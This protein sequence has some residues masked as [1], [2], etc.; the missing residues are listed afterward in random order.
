MKAK[1]KIKETKK[2]IEEAKSQDIIKA[3]VQDPDNMEQLKSV[4]RSIDIT[5]KDN[6]KSLIELGIS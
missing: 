2:K 6:Q 5:K 1:E 3:C 4:I